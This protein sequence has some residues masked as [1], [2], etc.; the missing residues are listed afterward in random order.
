MSEIIISGLMISV[1][2]MGVVFAFLIVLFFAMQIIAK[3]LNF[4]AKFFPEPVLET[5]TVKKTDNKIDEEI[6]VAIAIASR[7]V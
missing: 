6:A 1:V 5:V 2:G 7:A 3:V 4:L